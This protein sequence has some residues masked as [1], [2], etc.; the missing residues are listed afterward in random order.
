MEEMLIKSI[1]EFSDNL[2]QMRAGLY[3]IISRL[4]NKINEIEKNYFAFVFQFCNF[5]LFDKIIQKK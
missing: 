1:N 4:E 3:G 2:E 5:Y